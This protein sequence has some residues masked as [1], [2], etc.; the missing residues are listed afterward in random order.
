[1]ELHLFLTQLCLRMPPEPRALV[2]T[3]Y[4]VG[5][6]RL[7]HEHPKTLAIAPPL[8]PPPVLFLSRLPVLFLLL[9][10]V[11]RAIA[12][13]KADRSAV[14]ACVCVAQ[15]RQRSFAHG[16]CDGDELGRGGGGGRQV[17][18]KKSFNGAG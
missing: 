1:M 10:R 14:G 6:R 4:P 15:Q 16:I 7:K 2:Y 5:Q 13:H 17:K 8:K 9:Q 18:R 12:A 3:H 11:L